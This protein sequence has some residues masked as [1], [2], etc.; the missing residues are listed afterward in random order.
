MTT[1]TN[2][3]LP[4]YRAHLVPEKRDLFSIALVA[5]TIGMLIV[6]GLS[7]LNSGFFLRKFSKMTLFINYIY[8]FPIFSMGYFYYYVFESFNNNYKFTVWGTFVREVF[9][10]SFN[11]FAAIVFALKWVSFKGVMNI[12]MVMYWLGALLLA[13][14]LSLKNLFHIPLNISKL[15][16]RI[17]RNIAVYSIS[18]WGISILGVT[19]QFVDTFAVAGLMGLGSAA[20]YSMAK[21]IISPVVIPSASVVNISIPLISDAWRRYDL[22]KIEE[23]YKKTAL[24]LLLVCGFVFYLIWVNTSDIMSLLPLKFYGSVSIL[25][26]T[27]K[28]ILI[29]GIARAIDFSTS[30]NAH[31]LQNSRRYYLVDMSCN[32]A[33]VILLIPLN[34]FLIKSFGL[35]GGAISIFTSS[36]LSNSFK[37][38]YLYAKEHIHPFSNK[39]FVLIIIFAAMLL[40]N[41][42]LNILIFNNLQ[43]SSTIM[44]LIKISIKSIVLSSIFIPLI[45]F[46]EISDDIN[47][48]IKSMINKLKKIVPF[49]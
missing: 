49:L 5:G 47:A 44:L 37:A 13:S 29:L 32:I 24:V 19:F 35:I 15:T 34:Y 12:Y 36:F 39:W 16:K 31:I 4:Y 46:F 3:F 9:Y 41:Y 21:L 2:K 7:Y 14:N 6:L 22:P 17:W 48:T 18:S 25:N 38:T 26:S 10:K 1:V 8:L 23:I 11:L 27:K 28:V 33:N 20:V 30:V 45:Y 42:L 43:S 40:L